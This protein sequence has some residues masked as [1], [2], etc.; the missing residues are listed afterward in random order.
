[1]SSTRNKNMPNDFHMKQKEYTKK[2]EYTTYKHKRTAYQ[3][4]LPCTGVNMGNM[5]NNVLSWNSTDIESSLYGIGSTNLVQKK[6]QVTPRIK[7]LDYLSFSDR[8]RT[9]LPEPLVIENCN[10]PKIFRR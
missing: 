3:N 8:M 2:A 1:M 9:Y 7:Y 4:N 5:P 10:R 6:G